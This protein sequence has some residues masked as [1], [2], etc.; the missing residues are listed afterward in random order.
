[1]TSAR[2]FMEAPTA[3]RL[4]TLIDDVNRLA[5]AG[6]QVSPKYRPTRERFAFWRDTALDA[7]RPLLQ[8]EV[9]A[10]GTP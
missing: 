4:D 7:L 3:A 10:N 6:R 9:P 1:M 2:F 8:Q 5:V